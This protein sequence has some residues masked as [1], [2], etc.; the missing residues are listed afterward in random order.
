MRRSPV[1]GERVGAS[2]ADGWFAVDQQRF[3]IVPAPTGPSPPAPPLTVVR[4]FA[5][6]LKSSTR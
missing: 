1:A 5:S 2:T 6:A 4:D 3:L